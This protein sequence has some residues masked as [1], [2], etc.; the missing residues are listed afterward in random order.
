[1]EDGHDRRKGG[2][3]GAQSRSTS[4]TAELDAAARVLRA[5]Q[6]TPDSLSFVG[7]LPTGLGATQRADI[8]LTVSRGRV[9]LRW[10]PHRHEV[11]IA[12][13]PEP[14]GIELVGSVDHL[15]L[16]YW[17]SASPAQAVGWRVQWTGPLSPN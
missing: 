9:V 12:P 10:T 4:E 17:G 1:V 13:A 8:T 5:L 6:G 14:T 3:A 7:D 2:I 11:S 16:A 15:E